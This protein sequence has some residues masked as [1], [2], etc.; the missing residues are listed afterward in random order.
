MKPIIIFLSLILLSI[1]L[2][3]QDSSEKHRIDFQLEECLNDE[4]TQS[5]VDI[6]LCTDD[7]LN[8]WDKEL[9]IVYQ[10]L[11]KLLTDDQKTTLRQ[12]QKEW[13]KYRDLEFANIDSIYNMDGTMWGQVRIMER[14]E[15]VKNRTLS[16]THYLEVL[17]F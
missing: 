13:I 12:A 2:Y 3:S 10:K 8:E 5:T 7:A 6:M 16:L 9:N 14:L 11:M 17:D 4:W 1:S 15:I